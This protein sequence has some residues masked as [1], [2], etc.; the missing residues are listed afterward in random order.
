MTIRTSNLTTW[1]P[2]K[3]INTLQRQMEQLFEETLAPLSTKDLGQFTKVPAAELQ[4][5]DDTI[6]LRLEVPGINPDDLNIEVTDKT[7]SIYGERKSEHT[8][9]DGTRSE[10][11]YGSFRRV[12]P[13]PTRVQNTE[14]AA[15]YKDGI[16]HLTLPKAAE[17][18]NKVVKVSVN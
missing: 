8:T 11:H 1:A 7:V 16:L 15:E 4:E 6:L 17:E 5:T 2:W 13:L 9:Q 12:V 14:T 10:F 18:R 3:D